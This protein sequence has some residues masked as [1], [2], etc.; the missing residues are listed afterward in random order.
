VGERLSVLA[1]GAGICE[2][3]LIHRQDA[4]TQRE[5]F[6]TKEVSAK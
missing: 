1:E 6:S 4:K 5:I 2:M 3:I